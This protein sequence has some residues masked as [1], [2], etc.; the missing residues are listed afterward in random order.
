MKLQLANATKSTR[1]QEVETPPIPETNSFFGP[2]P[3]VSGAWRAPLI[4]AC[5]LLLAGTSRAEEAP[6]TQ[7]AGSSSLLRAVRSL[8]AK[9]EFVIPKMLSNAPGRNV[10]YYAVVAEKDS[11]PRAFIYPSR[12]WCEGIKGHGG[13]LELAVRVKPTGELEQFAFVFQRESPG[14]LKRCEEW[15]KNLTGRNIFTPPEDTEEV[16]TVTGA[17]MTSR[18]VLEILRRSGRK[19]SAALKEQTASP[20]P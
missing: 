10:E 3:K 20:A 12:D 1:H 15:F 5:L 18:A 6:L 14:Y 13:R 8:L 16:D 9:G 2:A 7:P 4:A 17:T 19:F 11:T